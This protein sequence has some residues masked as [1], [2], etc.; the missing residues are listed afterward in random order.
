MACW[1]LQPPWTRVS[2]VLHTV[3]SLHLVA[4]WGKEAGVR[5]R[6]GLRT[7][8]IAW[9]LWCCLFKGFG[10]FSKISIPVKAKVKSQRRAAVEAWP[11]C[12]FHLKEEKSSGKGISLLL[13]SSFFHMAKAVPPEAGR[14][15]WKSV[16]IRA[17]NVKGDSL[18]T[19]GRTLGPNAALLTSG[20]YKA[21]A[22]W[23]VTPCGESLRKPFS[24]RVCLFYWDKMIA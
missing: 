2:R 8:V 19:E 11:L 6:S 15:F 24:S 3:V 22:P 16:L 9:R 12:E 21:G 7:G 4:V 23:R 1:D 20:N 5:G 13:N 10:E 17:G 14:S 18:I